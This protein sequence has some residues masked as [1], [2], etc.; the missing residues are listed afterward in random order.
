M[1]GKRLLGWHSVRVGV[2]RPLSGK[3]VTM[4]RP[5]PKRYQIRSDV[6]GYLLA[7]GRT[8]G[9]CIRAYEGTAR[10]VRRAAP[11]SSRF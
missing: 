10:T 4:T 9:E 3:P 7:S 6:S 11:T 1:A 5:A 2:W 8:R